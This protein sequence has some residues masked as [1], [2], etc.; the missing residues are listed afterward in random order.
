MKMRDQRDYFWFDYIR[1]YLTFSIIEKVRNTVQTR[2]KLREVY[3]V[4]V[5]IDGT[6]VSKLIFEISFR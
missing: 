3:G 6:S 4:E 1:L 5:Y 2:K